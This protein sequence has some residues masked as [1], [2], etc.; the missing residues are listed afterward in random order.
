MKLDFRK[1]CGYI[2]TLTNDDIKK[3]RVETINQ[4]KVLQYLK[5]N[6]DIYV[7]KLTLY[8]RNTIKIV[9]SNDRV[10]YFKYNDK[11]KQVDFKEV[12]SDYELYL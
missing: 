1:E 11:T 3:N 2:K 12:K 5:K 6:L 8:D 10:G 4:Y 7:F 9:D